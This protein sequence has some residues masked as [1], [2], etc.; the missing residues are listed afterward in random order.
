MGLH[1]LRR[2]RER[3]T[4]AATLDRVLGRRVADGGR[5][6]LAA[7]AEVCAA[8]DRFGRAPRFVSRLAAGVAEEAECC[9]EDGLLL[10]EADK[11]ALHG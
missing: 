3:S 2:S 1:P 4:E 9:A 7:E 6:E 8:F 5:S 10:R 11:H